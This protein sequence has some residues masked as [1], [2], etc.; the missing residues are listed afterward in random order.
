MTSGVELFKMLAKSDRVS[1][2]QF[3]YDEKKGY[4]PVLSGNYKDSAG[5]DCIISFTFNGLKWASLG[6]FRM[7]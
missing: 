6:T 1:D 4:A 3:K 5:T 7:L 2:V